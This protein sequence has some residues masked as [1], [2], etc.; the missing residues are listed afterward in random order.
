VTHTSE[1]VVKLRVRKKHVAFG[2]VAVLG[3]CLIA[4]ELYVLSPGVRAS[5]VGTLERNGSW[6]T[7]VGML[8]DDSQVVRA[9]AGDALVRHG[10]TPVPALVRGLDRL[11]EPGRVL[12]AFTLGR[13]GPEAR[14]AIPALRRRM[15]SD[16]SEQVREAA[17]KALGPVARDDPAVVAELLGLLETGDDAGRIAA[18]GAAP[19]LSEADRWRAMPLLI[20]LLKHSNPR[21]REEAAE[22]L[23]SLGVDGR[24]AV[25]ALIDA[26]A[27]PDPKAREAAGEALEDISRRVVRDD[28]DL[29]TR[30]NEALRKARA[31]PGP[32][33]PPREP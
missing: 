27:D 7:L 13:I 24:A 31:R 28:P 21:A 4:V 3:L 9:A 20:Q 1:G 8:D 32:A 11:T 17:A 6:D 29:Y 16:E 10:A 12:V 30:V 23:G 19:G 18:A 5:S 14:E 15:V 2:V 26:L 22:A 33:G 25:P